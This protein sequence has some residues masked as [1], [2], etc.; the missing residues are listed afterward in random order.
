MVPQ[1]RGRGGGDRDGA[2]LLLRGVGAESRNGRRA[3]VAHGRA[4]VLL[5]HR[6]RL[7]SRLARQAPFVLC[8]VPSPFFPVQDYKI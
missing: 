2:V 4:T 8:A 3:A 5:L 6:P 7:R 1:V